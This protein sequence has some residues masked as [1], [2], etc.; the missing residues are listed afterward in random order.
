ME[1]TIDLVVK[2]SNCKFYNAGDIVRFQGALIEKDQSSNLC[3]TALNAVF[4]FIYAA[5]KGFIKKD[6]LQCPDCKDCVIFAIKE[7]SPE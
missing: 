1:K 5:R 7:H 3:M 4:P 6:D 2:K